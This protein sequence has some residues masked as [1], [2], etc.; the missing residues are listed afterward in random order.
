[1]SFLE[2][3]KE[4]IIDLEDNKEYTRF[5]NS[6]NRYNKVIVIG[7]GGSNAIASHMSQDFVKFSGK[8]SLA[9]SDPSMLTCFINDFGMENAYVKFL[10]AYADR[11]TLVIL[12]SSSGNSQN[13]VNCVH[14]CEDK[15][16][17]YG[18][19]TAFDKGNEMRKAAF[20]PEFN[21][22]LDTRSYAV[23][24]CMHQVFLHRIV[25]S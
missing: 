12:I 8:R 2:E 20:N 22:H 6:F 25:N 9:F 13:I 18:M 3:C 4:A 5:F 14:Y 7:N 17:P 16:I 24:E 19:L 1:M 10:E 15:S 23:A 11:E 21:Y